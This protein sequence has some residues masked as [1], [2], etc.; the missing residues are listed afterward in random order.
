MSKYKTFPRG[1]IHPPDNMSCTGDKA[2]RNAPLPTQAIIP[3]SQHIGAPAECIVNVGDI[4]EEEQLIGKSSG[5]VS[6]PVHS[7]VPGKVVEI[8]DIY[9]PHGKRSK[10]VVVELGGEF[11]R[12]GKSQS[13]SDWSSLKP[14]ELIKNISEMGIAGQGGATFPTHVKL[15]LPEGRNC[16]YLLVNAVECEPYLTSDQNLM[17]ENGDEI[18][19]GLRILKKILNPEKIIIAIESN[20]MASFKVMTEAVEKSGLDIGIEI[21]DVKYP[22]GAEKNLIHAV[23]G[24][25]VPSGKLPLDIGMVVINVE[26]VFSIFEAIVFKKPL[27]ERIVT[28]GGGAVKT[29]KTLRVKIGTTYRELLEECDGLKNEPVSVISGGPMMGFGV[30][31]LDTPVTKGTSG[32][33][34]LTKKEIKAA[35]QTACIACGR[36]I[37][38]C[39]MGLNPTEINKLSL[40]FLFD[41]AKETGLLDCVECGSCAFVCPAHIPLVQSF[42]MGKN[43]I[44]LKMMEKKGAGK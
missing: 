38:A 31:D 37:K 19:E 2:I 16:D 43:Q 18:V 1:G 41:E 9:L 39:S 12:M 14:K 7:S 4:I 33:L 21:L 24:K 35:K 27:V 30:Y 40:N 8:K 42:R 25:E 23:T 28:I 11:K 20:E 34:F 26:T 10:A 3:L 29:P 5:Y 36:C 15:V 32:I 6:S 17:L 13:K 44:R 22:Q